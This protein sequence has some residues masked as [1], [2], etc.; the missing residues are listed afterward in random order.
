MDEGFWWYAA[1][2]QHLEDIAD[3]LKRRALFPN[4]P[5]INLE[6]EDLSQDDIR[7]IMNRLRKGT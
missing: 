7:Y 5:L 4:K 1:H 3:E 6:Q 2:F